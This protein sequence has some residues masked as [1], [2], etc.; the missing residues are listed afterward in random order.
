MLIFFAGCKSSRV[1]VRERP[2]PPHYSQPLAP[3]PN[4]VWHS[5]EW[6]RHRHTYIYKQGFW[7]K[8]HPGQRY[9]S[10]GHWQRRRDGWI[11]IPGYWH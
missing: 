5:G 8:A 6:I 7:I 4:Y 9:Y 11:W 10:S 1:V 3:G 2:V